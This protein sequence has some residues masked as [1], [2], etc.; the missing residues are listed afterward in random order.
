M[1][2]GDLAGF[3][4]SLSGETTAVQTLLVMWEADCTIEADAQDFVGGICPSGSVTIAIGENSQQINLAISSD[5]SDAID[6]FGERF[7]VSLTSAGLPVG[8]AI[9]ENAGTVEALIISADAPTVS[10][11]DETIAEGETAVFIIERSPNVSPSEAFTVTVAVICHV[12]GSDEFDTRVTA[13]DIDNG[14]ALCSDGESREIPAGS[15][16]ATVSVTTLNDDIPESTPGGEAILLR[17]GGS[18]IAVTRVTDDDD[19]VVP[20]IDPVVTLTAALSLTAESTTI[21]EGSPAEFVIALDFAD[22]STRAVEVTWYVECAPSGT[23]G[24]TAEDLQNPAHCTPDNNFTLLSSALITVPTIDDDLAEFTINGETLTVV[25]TTTEGVVK[26]ASI[27]IISDDFISVGFT[28]TELDASEGSSLT[29]SIATLSGMAAEPTTLI[30]TFVGCVFSATAG[31][32]ANDF[33]PSGC[34]QDSEVTLLTDAV[35]TITLDF[36]DD[37][38]AEGIEEFSIEIAELALGAVGIMRTASIATVRVSDERDSALSIMTTDTSI[39]SEGGTANFRVSL[40]SGITADEPLGVRWVADCS[41]TA[42][43]DD[44]FGF[45]GCPSGTTTIPQGEDSVILAVNT[46][47]DTSF[48]DTEEFQ[49]RIINEGL[50]EGFAVV[51]DEAMGAILDDDNLVIGFNPS[52]LLIAEG[53]TF[54][55][56]I[57]IGDAMLNTSTVTVSISTVLSSIF[58]DDCQDGRAGVTPNDFSPN[59][60][61]DEVITFSPGQTV[62]VFTFNVAEDD[63]AEGTE[64][65][66]LVAIFEGMG[67]SLPS[68]SDEVT[69]DITDEIDSALSITPPD[70]PFLVEGTSTEFRVSLPQGVTPDERLELNWEVVCEPSTITADDFENFAECPAGGVVIES[71]ASETVIPLTLSSDGISEPLDTSIT[72]RLTE[73]IPAGFVFANGIRTATLPIFDADIPVI[74][75]VS[76]SVTE[77]D[78]A[79][80]RIEIQA[81]ATE[82]VSG[83]Y[84][85]DC[86]LAD[87]GITAAD[88]QN[89]TDCDPNNFTIPI[90]STDIS[91]AIQTVDDELE[92]P[93]VGGELLTVLLNGSEVIQASTRIIDNEPVGIGF[94]AS[95]IS[96]SILEGGAPVELFVRLS[97]N[98]VGDETVE[99]DFAIVSGTSIEGRDYSLS[100]STGD[101]GVLVFT[102][103]TRQLPII[104]TPLDDSIYED[105]ETFSLV[106]ANPVNAVLNE[107]AEIEGTIQDDN[108]DVAIGFLNTEFSTDEGT[109]ELIV[110]VGYTNNSSDV[111]IPVYFTTVDGSA[112][113]DEDYTPIVRRLLTFGG[114]NPPI[115]T[116]TVA[117]VMDG[118]IESNEDFL[119][120]LELGSEFDRGPN[121]RRDPLINPNTA[122]LIIINDNSLAF[123]ISAMRNLRELNLSNTG[124]SGDIGFQ[125]RLLL[126]LERLDLEG[127]PNLF[128]ELPYHIWAKQSIDEGALSIVTNA[129][130]TLAAAE[131][132]SPR[133]SS[134]ELL[135]LS[136]EDNSLL[137]GDF[138]SIFSTDTLERVIP[139]ALIE[140]V[141]FDEEASILE[142]LTTSVLPLNTPGPLWGFEDVA[143]PRDSNG[144][145]IIDFQVEITQKLYPNSEG[146]Y[147]LTSPPDIEF[148][149]RLAEVAAGALDVVEGFIEVSG[150][151]ML[152][153]P[154]DVIIS[155]DPLFSSAN[156]LTVAVLPLPM[157]PLRRLGIEA[158]SPSDF[159]IL[160]EDNLITVSAGEQSEV[161]LII[162]DDSVFEGD[163]ELWILFIDTITMDLLAIHTVAITDTDRITFGND[164][165]FTVPG[166]EGSA[167]EVP[168]LVDGANFLDPSAGEVTL[169]ILPS[170]ADTLTGSVT[171]G[172]D[173]P[174]E[175]SDFVLPIDIVDDDL[176]ERTDESH[177]LTLSLVSANDNV[178]DRIDVSGFTGA[179]VTIFDTDVLVLEFTQSVY[180]VSEGDGSIEISAVLTEGRVANDFTDNSL[181]YFIEAQNG[182]ANASIDYN[183]TPQEITILLDETVSPPVTL[184][185]TVISIVDDR[186]ILGDVSFTVS[187]EIQGG[188]GERVALSR[189]TATVTIT[190]DED[191]SRIGFSDTLTVE[192]IEGDSARLLD[193]VNNSDMLVELN[194]VG[195]QGTASADDYRLLSSNRLSLA[196][197]AAVTLMLEILEDGLLEGDEEFTLE[198]RSTLG[199]NVLD[200]LTIEI[201]ANGEVAFGFLS[202]DYTLNEDDEDGIEVLVGATSGGID[203][204]AG[205]FTLQLDRLAS[206]T[207]AEA[208]EDEDYEPF[209]SIITVSAG[210]IPLAIP[211]IPVNDNIAEEMRE[212]FQLMLSTDEDE[213]SVT[214]SGATTTVVIED[215]D[216]LT[217]EFAPSV[218]IREGD[219]ASITLTIAVTS[220]ANLLE[221][222]DL[223]VNIALTPITADINDFSSNVETLV[224]SP[225]TLTQTFTVFI[226]DD[227]LLEGTERFEIS[228]SSDRAGVVFSSASSVVT[229]L[230]NDGLTIGF[231]PPLVNESL[232]E[233]A[234]TVEFTVSLSGGGI[235]A[236]I[237]DVTVAV[238]V[239]D[240]DTA[241]D[242]VD[243]SLPLRELVFTEGVTSLTLAVSITDDSLVENPEESFT[244]SL[245]SRNDRVA[246]GGG[247]SFSIEDNDRAVVDFG[248]RVFRIS[249]PSGSEDLVVI[250]VNL[251]SGI[252]DSGLE[253]PV[254]V[255]AVTVS[256]NGAGLGSDYSFENRELIFSSVSETSRQLLA[257]ILPDDL[258]ENDEQFE[259]ALSSN[260][261]RVSL[262]DAP[263]IV[264]IVDEDSLVVS[265]ELESDTV[266]ETDSEISA[267]VSL[268]SGRLDVGRSL[269]VTVRTIGGTALVGE[270][271]TAVDETV[272]F[273]G[274]D[275]LTNAVSIPI[276]D[277]IGMSVIEGDETVILQVSI[278]DPAASIFEGADTI[279][280]T[281]TDSDDA[282]T[283]LVVDVLS[284]HEDP[285]EGEGSDEAIFTV[286]LEESSSEIAVT[287]VEDTIVLWRVVCDTFRITPSDFTFVGEACP[288]GQVTIPVG[289]SSATFAVMTMDDTTIEGDEI[290]RVEVFDVLN[291]PR[292]LI[293][294]DSRSFKE[295]AI[296]DDEGIGAEILLMPA[297]VNEGE[298]FSFS[299]RLDVAPP[300]DVILPWEFDCS[301]ADI[302]P[303]DFDLSSDSCPRGMVTIPNGNIESNRVDINISADAL[304]EGDEVFTIRIPTEGRQAPLAFNIQG[305]PFFQDVMILDADRTELELIPLSTT[306]SEGSTSSVSF[307]V[308][309]SNGVSVDE[310]VS[311]RWTVDCSGDITAEDFTS[312]GLCPTG[313]AVIA[314]SSASTEIIV[315][316]ADDSVIEFS[317]T[318]LVT[319]SDLNAGNY[320]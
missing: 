122:D 317:E 41:G 213:A 289:Q 147:Q 151:R 136:A 160:A 298:S 126:D 182:S 186:E 26:R 153:E 36:M 155:V 177:S 58:D 29:V 114:D 33:S 97:R 230:D 228:P 293:P 287:S 88:L 162:N 47:E 198:L 81:A 163:E 123:P 2:E 127:T 193:V 164:G 10:A 280:A 74:R 108:D 51:Q 60:C 297:E 107:S 94:T 96:P 236:S 251:V 32:T 267:I 171:L 116:I 286:R 192:G 83:T 149:S 285:E 281:I 110:G 27:G 246:I 303:N 8:Y 292:V 13:E 211:L 38:L 187:L 304:V 250:E 78:V 9:D 288:S 242:G 195:V 266:A 159:R 295:L 80:F 305:A 19:A 69:I 224:F 215:D 240:D 173:E 77:G 90:G 178:R 104:V 210:T 238:M 283:V 35:V 34:L 118:I 269:N 134:A 216:M 196:S 222:G 279:T 180:T 309:L 56:S 59:V 48:E 310:D 261:P 115:Q 141:I 234:G 111:E 184:S 6:T 262:P 3:I 185:G 50:P 89:P 276:L 71:N 66:S 103:R 150:D 167:L 154:Q 212:G 235:D 248:Q 241:L 49:I 165:N 259:I 100:T 166:M 139:T 87:P 25:V 137:I 79:E 76:E 263:A 40:P 209:A 232:S 109:G 181:T 67:D 140:A 319:L 30:V 291:A 214:I 72:V 188:L 65:F 63:L 290:F 93:T 254:L 253:L 320:L 112:K 243:Y 85:V 206:L 191:P 176:V 158:A 274:G 183:L 199:E 42:S 278:T 92:E 174:V 229:I 124:L 204:S 219:A 264:T 318:L 142:T 119:G 247:A 23:A 130:I 106:L 239:G 225:D 311:F 64:T 5:R 175:F 12:P 277:D 265:F 203:F 227:D 11:V 138:L 190:E 135:E 312:D 314:R 294:S 95:A 120:L 61:P 168:V 46:E 148:I 258:V 52:S 282:A 307:R 302:T 144:Q 194:V 272:V 201:P 208:L 43:A 156:V 205:T 4:V 62:K 275:V 300:G 132:F 75:A 105:T 256:V 131:T 252:I 245:E 223:S 284:I 315:E 113:A 7:A 152:S 37:N 244:L 18:N 102:E 28:D 125:T 17:A 20:P 231:D 172:A 57:S 82:P 221:E 316:I 299:V 220:A 14:A 68:M 170:G 218:E 179:V 128:G 313:S 73:E 249:E 99:V 268:S 207:L 39:V 21:N 306:A 15:M 233:A 197:G 145:F 146:E 271:Y 200:T 101:S 84:Q 133:W 157:E 44:F 237:G 273:I 129:A 301:S 70:I 189:T 226:T 54:M 161:R 1:R 16:T 296:I 31:I 202:A 91:V 255:E 117:L 169:Q 257:F 22:T 143:S 45:D 260:D 308:S 98:L 217:L 24:I 86:A 270:D 121:I 55:A 53:D